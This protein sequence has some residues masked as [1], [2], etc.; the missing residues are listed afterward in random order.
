MTVTF[1]VVYLVAGAGCA[2]TALAL[3]RPVDAALLLVLW[4]LYGPFCLARR[5]TPS[6]PAPAPAASA[7]EVL[8][9]DQAMLDQL[10]RRVADGRRRVAD[11]DAVLARNG[12]SDALVRRL[13]GLRH[14]CERE[15]EELDALCKQLS[16]QAEVVRLV[17]A[18]E[19]A[20]RDLVHELEARAEGLDQLLA[21]EAPLA[22]PV[23]PRDT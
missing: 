11:I 17:G 1:A 8:I 20:I 4:P 14:R 15:L 3:R 12:L 22:W 5:D 7:L 23:G 21:E 2:I 19:P 10:A 16:A 13:A 6:P 9:P 18:H